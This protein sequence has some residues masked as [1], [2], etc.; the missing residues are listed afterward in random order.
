MNVEHSKLRLAPITSGLIGRD[1]KILLGGCHQPTLL[2][3]L[4]GVPKHWGK[5]KTLLIQFSTE[6]DSLAAYA[7]DS[8]DLAVIEV[9]RG[10]QAAHYIHDLTRIARKG[11]I[12]RRA[13]PIQG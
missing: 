10:E 8:F 1:P 3:Y 11:L 5:P 7:T 4:D 2:R 12:T 6:G 9:P 13:L